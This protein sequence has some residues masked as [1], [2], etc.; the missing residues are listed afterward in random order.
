MVYGDTDSLFVELPG[1]SKEDAFRIGKEIAEA[2]T[3][4]CPAPMELK[5]DKVY[6]GCIL[7]AKKRYVG[8]KYESV[9][10]VEPQFEGKGIEIVRRDTVRLNSAILKTALLTMFRTYDVQ[11]VRTYVRR[12]LLKILQGGIPVS[13]FVFATEFKDGRYKNP[14]ARPVCRIVEREISRGL[15]RARYKERVR[16]V[17]ALGTGEKLQAGMARPPEDVLYDPRLMPDPAYYI[18]KQVLPT[19]DRMFKLVRRL[20]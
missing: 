13:E 3:R 19:L 7:C 10:Q 9:N 14:G 1:R 12:Q 17:L 15:P 20:G 2:V 11:Q 16:Y 5:F 8:M 6:K 18:Q 4:A